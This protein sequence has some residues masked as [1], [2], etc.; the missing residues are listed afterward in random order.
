MPLVDGLA[1][2]QRAVSRHLA[3]QN[4]TISCILENARLC[5]GFRNINRRDDHLQPTS[6]LPTE[7]TWLCYVKAVTTAID[8]Q[9]AMTRCAHDIV[10]LLFDGWKTY[11]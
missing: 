11:V 6:Q 7:V 3:C 10:R 9:L 1:C 4:E 5:V 2:M 8:R